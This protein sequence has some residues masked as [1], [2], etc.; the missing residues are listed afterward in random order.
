MTCSERFPLAA[1]LVPFKCFHGDTKAEKLKIFNAPAVNNVL[2]SHNGNAR[3][4]FILAGMYKHTHTHTHTSWQTMH[5]ETHKWA[6]A[7]IITHTHTH[8]HKRT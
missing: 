8:K 5:T 2:C 3:V 4:T 1:T 7:I 6:E